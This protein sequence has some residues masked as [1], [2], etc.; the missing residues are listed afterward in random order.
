MRSK[1]E[2]DLLD[3]EKGILTTKEDTQALRRSR[4]Q[5]LDLEAYLEFLAGFEDADP[6]TLIRRRGPG[7]N[8]TFEL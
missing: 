6:S 7:G 5:A 4:F 1:E 8:D 3:L 2:A